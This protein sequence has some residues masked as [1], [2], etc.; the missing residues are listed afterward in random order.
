MSAEKIKKRSELA[1][2][3]KRKKASGKRVGFTNG[4]F[5]IL[6][7]GHV[8]Y[9]YEARNNCDILIIGV[10]S[11]DSVKRLKGD[12]RPLN[13]QGARL[14]VLASLESVSFVTLF[15]EDTPMEL[16]E[17]LSPDVL[18]KGGDWDEKD[19]VGADHVKA[20]G[21]EVKVIEYVEGFSTSGLIDQIKEKNHG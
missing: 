18:F 11:D 5:D 19:I 4:C 9:L 13:E 1:E 15:D 14:E 8:K 6:H 3:I 16:I 7:L 10:N 21:G 17:L 12:E 2:I 20:N